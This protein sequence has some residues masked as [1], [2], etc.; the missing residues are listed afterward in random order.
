MIWT[1]I[2]R[3]I[4]TNLMTFRFFVTVIACMSLVIAGTVVLTDNYERRLASYNADF[5]THQERTFIAKTY[6]SFRA[7]IDRA[8]N[9]LSLFNQG[10]DKRAKNSIRIRIGKVPFLWDNVYQHQSTGFNNPFR[11]LLADIDLVSIFQ[12]LL[13]LLAL[14]FA[15]DAIAGDRENGT[16]RLILANPVGRGVVILGKYIGAIVCLTLPLLISF[17]FALLLQLQSSAIQYT[18]D[19]FL[20]IGGILLTTIVYIST[21]YLIGLFISSMIHRTATSLIVSMF[22]WVTLTLLY[23]NVSLFLVNRLIDTEEK[24]E[25]VNR[26]IEQVSDRYYRDEQKLRDPFESPSLLKGSIGSGGSRGYL[27]LSKNLTYIPNESEPNIPTVKAYFQDLTS[28]HIRAAETI[29]RIRKNAFAETYIRKSRIARNAL[30][31]SPA[32]LYHLST[33]AWAGTDIARMEHFFETGRQYR[34]RVLDYFHD[35]K[36]FSSRQ[37]FASDKGAVRWDD[38]PRF[39]YHPPD[40]FEDANSRALPDLFLLSLLNL[41]LFITTFMIFSRQEV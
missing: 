41:V 37:W 9:P 24:I 7:E 40:V 23:P 21:F 33:E 19:D 16:L 8:P 3:E 26:E 30:R 11:H 25:Q 13:S 18:I 36:A 35:K 12:I 34:Q 15:Y 1:L 31:F 32:G 10:L 5:Q 2:Q 27:H 22:I 39:T 20:R 6:S 38:A 29:W 17:L 28:L 14:V 4:L